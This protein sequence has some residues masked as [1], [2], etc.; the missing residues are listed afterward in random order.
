MQITTNAITNTVPAMD[1][2]Q[3]DLT[4]T[5]V[6]TDLHIGLKN[7]SKQHNEWCVQFIQYMIE[8]AQAENIKT[9]L[10]LGDWSHNRSSV[11][12]V[13]LNYSLQ[14]LR[15]LS[16]AFDNVIMI[17]GN[18]DLYFR[19]KLDM[20]SIPYVQEFDNIHLITEITTQGDCVFVPWLV[21]D[22]WKQIPKIKQP[23]MLC[24]A[25]IAR[26]KM[27]AMVEL[28]DHGGLNSDHFKNQELVISGHFHKRQRKGKVLY[29][30]NAFPHNY[31]DVHDDDRGFMFWQ[32]GSEPVFHAWPGAPKYRTW[33]LSQVLMNPTT[34]IDDH[35]F[36][37]INVDVN[38]NYEDL[39]FV[40]E[41][42]E[43]ELQALDVTW[44]HT[45]QG[46]DTEFTDEDIQFES[47]DQIVLDHL[48]AIES[49]TMDRQL[50][51]QIY[52][53]I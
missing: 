41:L 13:T 45:K 25:E 18:H 52:Q 28:P 2:S 21:G 1:L 12:V 6:F 4:H 16:E 17:L 46:A 31:S 38:M 51:T 42:F 32:P 34:Y 30:G 43:Q 22:Q 37:K 53:S 36:V 3:V 10:F 39:N 15:M 35:T 23:Y 29:M 26:F 9:C 8:Q 44:V 24:H 33:E 40:K 47:V 7:N 5:V 14:C 19:D 49:V 50:L 27:N 20:H 11:S 48:N